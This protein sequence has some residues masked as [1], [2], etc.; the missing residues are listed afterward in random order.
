MATRKRR[1]CWGKDLD[2]LM[3]EYH[4]RE[5][6]R[7]LHDDRGIFEFLVLEGM[8]AGL[9]W[10]LV[11][12]KREN[13]RRAF[14]GFDPGKV[15]RFTA[16]DVRRLLADEGIVRNRLKIEAAIN[17]A[18]RFL[19]VQKEFGSFDRYIWGFV[20]G[21]PV[22]NG[23]RSFAEMPARTPL[24][25]RISKDLKARGFKFVGST[26]VYSHMQAT[27]MVN[28]HLAGCFRCAARVT[29]PPGPTPRPPADP[30][31]RGRSVRPR[32]SGSASRSAPDADRG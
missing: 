22:L 13:F 18:R 29:P 30:A 31:R 24:S 10:S 23:L 25:D 12:K 26:I 17:N 19:E 2:P 6:G 28:D 5:W 32:A 1:C 9:N 11:L 14:R 8:Q 4:D 16:R 20:E 15:A 27:G 21:R 7:P 3:R